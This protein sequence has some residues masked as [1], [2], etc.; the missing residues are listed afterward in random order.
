MRM[1]HLKEVASIAGK[2]SSRQTDFAHNMADLAA[3]GHTHGHSNTR[4]GDLLEYLRLE[5]EA[6]NGLVESS[7]R[8]NAEYAGQGECQRR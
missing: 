8:E 2:L 7:R 4:L 1:L 6:L 3:V 5:G